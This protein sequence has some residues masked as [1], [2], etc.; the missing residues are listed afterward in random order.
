MTL[1]PMPHEGRHNQGDVREMKQLFR[2]FV[3]KMS[4]FALDKARAY[5]NT[6]MGA[7]PWSWNRLISSKRL[8][9]ISTSGQF[10]KEPSSLNVTLGSRSAHL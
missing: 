8:R 9:N 3:A 1:I 4:Y 5:V 6:C 7:L 10:E 2:W